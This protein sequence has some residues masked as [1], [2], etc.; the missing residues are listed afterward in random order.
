MC[1]A[2]GSCESAVMDLTAS[3]GISCNERACTAATFNMLSN[4]DGDIYCAGR[5]SCVGTIMNID[6]GVERIVCGAR[7]ACQNAVITLTNPKT[8]FLLFYVTVVALP[9]SYHQQSCHHMI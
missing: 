6:G 7:K 9:M 3:R 1:K 8:E 2:A 4:L 5:A